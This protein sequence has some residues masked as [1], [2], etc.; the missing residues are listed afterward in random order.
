MPETPSAC[1]RANPKEK[2]ARLRHLSLS[3]VPP[4]S[5]LQRER[6]PEL[7]AAL[8]GIF[9]E[10]ERG[11]FS[12][13]TRVRKINT[14][15][16]AIRVL[17]LLLLSS[18]LLAQPP[19]LP[20]APKPNG[21]FASRIN[22]GLVIGDGLARLLDA[23]STREA[24]TCLCHNG[25]NLAE[26]GRFFGTSLAPIAAHTWS[27]YSYSLGVA[28]GFTAISHELWGMSERHPPHGRALR[29]ASRAVLVGDIVYDGPM[30]V[31][32]WEVIHTHGNQ[33][34]PAF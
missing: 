34:F 17:M 9:Q 29:L 5:S 31:N 12:E 7:R 16:I 10:R 28:A 18:S 6:L 11:I 33:G 1:P 26:G 4:I 27:Q 14:R 23:V 22:T 25:G 30:P 8:Y 15:E 21:F 20:E 2:Q 19:T 32:N 13:G 24:V 3:E